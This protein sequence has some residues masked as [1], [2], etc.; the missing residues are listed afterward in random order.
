VAR[1][2]MLKELRALVEEW[3]QP[4][5]PG[6]R[7]WMCGRRVHADGRKLDSIMARH[8]VRLYKRDRVRPDEF[9][10][11]RRL[12]E[13]G[14]VGECA[15]LRYWGLAEPDALRP[16]WWR[17]TELGRAFVRGEVTVPRKVWVYMRTVRHRSKNQTT[18]REA[19]G[20]K[21][22]LDEMLASE[23]E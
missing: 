17:I 12:M 4:G 1:Y 10:D 7:C 6:R 22:D 13:R 21:F 14:R 20:D 11:Y 15:S 19:L 3:L 9:V 23:L 18:I 2:W 5:H 16:G 8:L